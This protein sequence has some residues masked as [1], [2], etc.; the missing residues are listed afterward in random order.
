[1]QMAIVVQCVFETL[2]L[3]LIMHSGV[4]WEYHIQVESADEKY[5][6]VEFVPGYASN[7]L[8]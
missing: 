5:A 1:M 8:S 6:I 3:P 4:G 7:W 2:S